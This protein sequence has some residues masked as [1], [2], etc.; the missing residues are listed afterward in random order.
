MEWAIDALRDESPLGNPHNVAAEIRS[1]MRMIECGYGLRVDKLSRTKI[2]M[3]DI[4]GLLYRKTLVFAFVENQSKRLL[5]LSML[6]LQ[7]TFEFV[8][9][10]EHG[11][12]IF[13]STSGMQINLT[14]FQPEAISSNG[15]H[16]QMRA[17]RYPILFV[18]ITLTLFIVFSFYY[19]IRLCGN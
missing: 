3:D 10:M 6:V 8:Y 15:A 11:K 13:E 14:N 19:F 17:V 1:K 4:E 9:F 16:Y 5:Y 12:D 7:F 18:V 2:T